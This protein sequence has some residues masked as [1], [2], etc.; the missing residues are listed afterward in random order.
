MTDASQWIKAADRVL[1]PIQGCGFDVLSD[2]TLEW[3]YHLESDKKL[4]L[5]VSSFAPD[6][7]LSWWYYRPSDPQPLICEQRG[8]AI[9]CCDLPNE[10][11]SNLL[12]K[13][14]PVQGQGCKPYKRIEWRREKGI[15]WYQSGV[16]RLKVQIP[17]TSTIG[18]YTLY[19]ADGHVIWK[20]RCWGEVDVHCLSPGFYILE[21][22]VAQVVRRIPIRML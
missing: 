10:I 7:E 11:D 5:V 8:T 4:L 21:T 19:T 18:A 2:N 16:G 22:E 13:P 17:E 1:L 14:C 12:V 20:E 3:S 6:Q 9:Y 15:A